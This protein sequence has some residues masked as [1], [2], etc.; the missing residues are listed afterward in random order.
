MRDLRWI[1]VLLVTTTLWGCADLSYVPPRV[2]NAA[3]LW[4]Q[5]NSDNAV[6]P[7]G[8]KIAADCRDN[9]L[10]DPHAMTIGA[11]QKARFVL[12][13]DEPFSFAVSYHGNSGGPD[14]VN[15]PMTFTPKAN[16]VYRLAF[17]VTG[18]QYRVDM[19]MMNGTG[20][21]PDP[22][23]EIK[24]MLNPFLPGGAWCARRE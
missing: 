7:V 17:T 2:E 21:S 12:R 8:Y 1:V 3:T 23:F 19:T 11:G 5:N 4:I 6:W 9:F 14:Y 15:L 16:G 18:R 22:T 20:E 24:R 10:L 13:P